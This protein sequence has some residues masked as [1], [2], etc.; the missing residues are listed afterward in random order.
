MNPW[1]VGDKAPAVFRASSCS[2]R[3]GAGD[4]GVPGEGGKAGDV[5]LSISQEE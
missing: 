2:A 4:S 5:F 3:E 1:S